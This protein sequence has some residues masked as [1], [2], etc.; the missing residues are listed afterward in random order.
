M[1]KAPFHSIDRITKPLELIHSDICDLKFVQTRGGKKY[2]ITFI[3]DCTKYCYV[4]L[5]RSKDEAIEMFK[6]YK[7]EVENQLS[8]KIK[9]IRSNRG[10]EYGP[11]FEQFF[12]QHG[13]IHQTNAPYS[14]QLNGVVERKNWTLKEMMNVML[15]SSGLPQNL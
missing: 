8:T 5:M 9:A 4:Y 15:I 10:D 14:P 6:L 13:I 7:N 2:F 1:T 11:P 12:E 3:D